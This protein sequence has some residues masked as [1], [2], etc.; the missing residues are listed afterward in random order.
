MLLVFIAHQHH[1][2]IEAQQFSEPQPVGD[3]QSVGE[4]QPDSE[5]QQCSSDGDSSGES[6]V[7]SGLQRETAPTDSNISDDTRGSK[8]CIGTCVCVHVVQMLACEY[9][10]GS[11][12]MS[13]QVMRKKN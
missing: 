4:P 13:V 7:V 1:P 2:V 10:R 9:H 5:P 6:K 12:Q 8:V 3:P 11:L